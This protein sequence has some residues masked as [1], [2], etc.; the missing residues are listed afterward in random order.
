MPH[1]SDYGGTSYSDVGENSEERD[2]ELGENIYLR[3]NSI[4]TI[5]DGPSWTEA[6]ANANKLGGHLVTINDADEN[7]FVVQLAGNYFTGLEHFYDNAQKYY[8]RGGEEQTSDIW[9]GLNDKKNEGEYEWS[10]G[11]PVDYL[12]L[13]HISSPRDS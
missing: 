1:Y 11:E 9:I 12:S 8:I 7:E 10:S 4:Y 3:E 6:E 13:I 2:L 5:V